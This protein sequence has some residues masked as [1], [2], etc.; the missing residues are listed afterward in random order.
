MR[1]VPRGP[2]RRLGE[3]CSSEATACRSTPVQISL[4]AASVIVCTVRDAG[5]QR[6]QH[7][8][9]A[10]TAPPGSPLEP[11]GH[12]IPLHRQL[13][14]LRVQLPDLPHMVPRCPLQTL[15]EDLLHPLH[16][17]LLPSAHLV[18]MN[19]V[20]RHDLLDCLVPAQCFL[21]Y[22]RFGLPIRT[23]LPLRI[24][25]TIPGIHFG[26]LP[27]FPGPPQILKTD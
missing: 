12:K 23:V 18:R 6:L 24:H 16:P 15:R 3:P 21:R 7:V 14:D 20:P 5:E 10:S 25:P 27:N 8:I 9:E 1:G 2:E 22:L 19:L 13:P 11:L 4:S 26:N 17:P